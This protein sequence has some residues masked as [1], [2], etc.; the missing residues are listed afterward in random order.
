MWFLTPAIRRLV[1]ITFTIV[2]RL[3]AAA[4]V[5]EIELLIKYE[6]GIPR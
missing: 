2:P 6:R 3:D 1:C 5:D 4:S